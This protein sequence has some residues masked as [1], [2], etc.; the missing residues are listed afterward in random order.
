[1]ED[2]YIRYFTEADFCGREFTSQGILM[3]LCHSGRIP[4]NIDGKD[5][6]L[7]ANDLLVLPEKVP[8]RIGENVHQ[9]DCTVSQLGVSTDFV[10]DMPSPIDTNIFI[11]SRFRPLLSVDDEKFADFASHF[12]FIAKESRETG[13]YRTIIIRSLVYALLLEITAEYEDQYQFDR[14]EHIHDESLTDRFFRLLALNFRSQRSIGWYAAQLSITPK[15]LSQVVK[16]HT[17]RSIQDWIHESVLIEARMLLKT[18]E[19]TV[20]QISDHLNFS[21]PSAFVQFFRK[22]TGHTPGAERQ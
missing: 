4:V 2:F 16:S 12:R 17:R 10:L 8:V 19:M 21:S 7:K 14:A 13:R 1:M 9:E 11:Y 18:T 5:Y 6:V 22:H 15:Y 3:M 20:Q